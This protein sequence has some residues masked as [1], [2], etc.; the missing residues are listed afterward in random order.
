[1]PITR[2]FLDWDEPFLTKVVGWLW[3]QRDELTGILV[4][5]PTAQSGRRLRSALLGKAQAAGVDGLLTP[6]IVTSSFFLQVG[7]GVA[8]RTQE[9]VAWVDVLEKITDWTPYTEAFPIRPGEGERAGWALGLAESLCHL[10]W[11][12]SEGEMTIAMASARLQESLEK[13]RW[14]ALAALEKLLESRLRGWG[15]QSHAHAQVNGRFD[16]PQGVRRIVVAGIGDAAA[17]LRWRWSALSENGIPI[18]LLISAPEKIASHFDEFGR[19][20]VDFW[21]EELLPTKKVY[22][23]RNHRDQAERA[24]ALVAESGVASD[25]LA[26]GAADPDL[27]A[28]LVEV[29]G[30]AGWPLFDSA[31]SGRL[32]RLSS[33]FQLWRRFLAD[34]RLTAVGDLLERSETGILV[35]GQL[36]Q[37]AKVLSELRARWLLDNEEDLE[38]AIAA[39]RRGTKFAD[40]LL[41][42]CRA[43]NAWRTE[44]LQSDFA[45]AMAHL[46]GVLKHVKLKNGGIADEVATLRDA[47]DNLA[48]LM[49]RVNHGAYFWLELILSALD[50]RREIGPDE[51]VGDVQGWLELLFEPGQKM[52]ICGMNEGLVPSRDVHNAWLVEATRELLGLPTEKERAARDAWLLR[53]F[54]AAREK[55]GQVDLICGKVRPNGDVL[56]PSRLL[57]AVPLADLAARVQLLFAE[58]EPP[59]SGFAWQ[60]DWKWKLTGQPK[61][62]DRVSVTAIKN[63]LLCPF[64]FYLTHVK[65]MSRIESGL[66]EW[67]NR[68]F[69]N[70]VHEVLE[71]WGRDSEAREFTKTEAISA[72]LERELSK[73]VNGYFGENWPLAVEIQ[74]ASMRQRLQ[75]FAR[76][77]AC[78]RADGWQV[79]EVEKKIE[80]ELNGIS[81]VGKVDRLDRHSDGTFRVIDYKTG[82]VKDS[83]EKLHWKSRSRSKAPAHLE[84]DERLYFQ[85]DKEEKMWVDLQLPLYAAILEREQVVAGAIELAYFTLGESEAGVKWEIWTGYESAIGDSAFDC[86]SMVIERIKA[87]EFWPPAEKGGTYDDYK[88]LISQGNLDDAVEWD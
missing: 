25:Q 51:R 32:L 37:K 80:F 44:F 9:K 60:R 85:D 54:L 49:K 66:V 20:L 79:V 19:P 56:Q 87:G 18:H 88:E 39:Q 23:E 52:V 21:Q 13:G 34:P 33:W 12:L 68:Q 16:P 65:K 84:D 47:L 59:E 17:L 67:D 10:R 28:D 38:R 42:A 26:L 83:V 7:E 35:K 55:N 48:P 82:K 45:D 57:L 78:A 69:G 63:Y 31:N 3:K 1:M 46:L 81:L 71:L 8:D 11:Q 74:V 77:Q 62:P 73:L 36:A 30:Q 70:L 76:L 5:V 61:I 6:K 27:G 22:L 43:L 86:A 50:E 24:L 14:T 72:W 53:S 41:E 4:V 15:F 2:E 64:R 75:W 40:G 58:I 29:F